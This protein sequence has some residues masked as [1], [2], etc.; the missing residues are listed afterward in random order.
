[1][2]SRTLEK[3]KDKKDARGRKPEPMAWVRQGVLERGD[4]KRARGEKR[5]AKDD[6]PGRKPKKSEKGKKKARKA[7]KAEKRRFSARSADK[8]ELYQ[9]AVQSPEED[10]R[11]LARV[12]KRLRGKKALHFREDF[13]GTGLLASHWIRR[14][15]EYTA[16]GFDID[17]EPVSWGLAHHFAE[18]GEDARRA[19]LHLKDVREPSARRPDVRAA[20]NFSYFTF[21]DR[22]V[23]L[24]YLRSACADLA[25]DGIFVLDIY[26]GPDAMKEMEEVRDIEE[27]FTYVWDQVCYWPAT[28]DYRAHIHF[29][30][31]DGTRME[32]AFSYKWR[33]WFLTE[34][35]DLLREA[36]FR[37]VVNYWEGTDED[38]ESGNGIYRPSRRGENCEAWVT[39]LVALK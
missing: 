3:K 34:I 5:R 18:L 23:M 22:K 27:G 36:G 30:F 37:D 31:K 11:F 35:T 1:M 6:A 38:G 12:Y 16:E 21:I 2:A 10:V 28:G 8:Y 26:G 7:G 13:C 20:Q 14:G 15:K 24:D 29:R 4:E 39:Y 25:H 19:T 17:P 32:R 33:L 9:F